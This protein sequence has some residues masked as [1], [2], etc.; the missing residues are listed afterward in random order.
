MLRPARNLRV[1][2]RDL[3]EVFSYARWRGWVGK[4]EE[5]IQATASKMARCSM[6]VSSSYVPSPNFVKTLII[7]VK[8]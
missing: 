6:P 4:E 8:I 1:C 3:G 5:E 2:G 7:H